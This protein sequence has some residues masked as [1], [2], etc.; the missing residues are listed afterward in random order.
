M[1]RVALGHDHCQL[2]ALVLPQRPL[3]QPEHGQ[4]RDEPQHLQRHPNDNLPRS[5]VSSG[6]A[7]SDLV[8]DLSV[9]FPD[10]TLG[11]GIHHVFI[12]PCRLRGAAFV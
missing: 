4:E 5:V 9:P 12:G 3:E 8:L 6:V 1:P 7:A 11:I 10:D 2:C